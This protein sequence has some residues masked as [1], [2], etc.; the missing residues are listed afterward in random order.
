MPDSTVADAI[1]APSKHGAAMRWHELALQKW[2]YDNFTLAS[3]YP[4]PAVFTA[5]MDA[6]SQ[7]QSL[8]KADN[9]PFKYLL[10]LKDDKG[11]PL[12]QPYPVQAKLPLLSVQRKGWRYRPGQNYSIHR[13]RRIAWPTVSADV[14]KRDLATVT[15]SRMPAAWNFKFQIDHF[16]VHPGTQ[17]SF[18]TDLM[19]TMWRSGGVPQTWITVEYPGHFYK[20][21]VRM[22]LDGEID[23]IT[24][25]E[26]EENQIVLRRTSF[27]LVVEGYNVDIDYQDYPAFWNLIYHGTIPGS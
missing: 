20:K 10:D 14:K 5:P 26:P 18:I 21:Q 22:W 6:F 4:I 16:C 3:G 9:N 1:V 23:D 13:W 15:T 12:Y 7:F 27:A 17:S 25:D 11:T 8:W 2:L 19:S 24:P